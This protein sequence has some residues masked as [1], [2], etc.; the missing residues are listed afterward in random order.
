MLY[1]TFDHAELHNY[2]S[3]VKVC[4]VLIHLVFE[5][6]KILAKIGDWE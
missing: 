5:I 2:S 3:Y 1:G 6:S 4:F